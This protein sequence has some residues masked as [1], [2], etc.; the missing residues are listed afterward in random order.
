[1]NPYNTKLILSC[2]K[3]TPN[4]VWTPKEADRAMYALAATAAAIAMAIA[5]I[6]YLLILRS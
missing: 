1:M 3:Q 4:S 6:A 2:P 5:E